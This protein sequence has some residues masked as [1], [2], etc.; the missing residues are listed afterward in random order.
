[1][2]LIRQHQVVTDDN[3]I[4]LAD[5]AELPAQGNV[6]VGLKRLL[7]DSAALSARAGK[8]GVRVDPED[9]INEAKQALDKV[10]LVA[11]SFPKFGDGRAYSKARLFRDR[12]GYKG[13]LRAVGE[14]LAD[15]LQYMLRCGFDAFQLS[16]GKDVAAALRALSDFTVTYQGASDDP[17]PLYRRVARGERPQ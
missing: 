8:L 3:W 12:F 11:L 7:A 2:P 15:Q 16:E 17:R 6:V 1:M 4:F 9:E 13:E 14:V 10:E 5:D